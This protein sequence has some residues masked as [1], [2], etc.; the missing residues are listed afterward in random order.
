MESAEGDSQRI[1]MK[2]CAGSY[3]ENHQADLEEIFPECEEPCGILL[4][5]EQ[6]R[7]VQEFRF[8]CFIGIPEKQVPL[9]AFSLL[10]GR[11]SLAGSV[12]GGIGET[13]EMLDFCGKHNI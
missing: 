3:E 11:R 1:T 6:W 4:S 5:G 8:P 12:I 9:G 13:Q 10:R 2:V 7:F